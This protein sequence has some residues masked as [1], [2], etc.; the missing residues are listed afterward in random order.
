[1]THEVIHEQVTK[2]ELTKANLTRIIR[3][4]ELPFFDAFEAEFPTKVRDMGRSVCGPACLTLPQILE[5]R[6]GILEGKFTRILCI[7]NP[8][9]HPERRV[10]QTSLLIPL[11][12]IHRSNL[13]TRF[14]WKN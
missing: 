4:I 1:M 2:T 13:S 6:E 7:Y 5:K 9:S 12:D 8:P 3:K 14:S 10:E 11:S